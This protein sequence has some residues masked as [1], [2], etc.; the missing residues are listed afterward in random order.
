M[1]FLNMK[2]IYYNISLFPLGGSQLYTDPMRLQH[3]IV[4]MIRSLKSFRLL[5]EC[6]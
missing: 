4:S 3:A 2:I 1:K 5:T 6:S